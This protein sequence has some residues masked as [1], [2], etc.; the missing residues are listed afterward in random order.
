[1][2]PEPYDVIVVG[3]G[4]AGLA[5]GATAAAGGASTLVL[6]AQRP[7]GR[8]RTIVRDGF[9][10]NLGP[11][12][13]YLGGPGMRVLRSLAV[14]PEGGSPPLGRYRLLAGGRLHLLPTSPG[15]LVRTTALGTRS[16]ARFGRLMAG[17]ARM[18]ASR[19]AGVSASEWLAGFGLRPD[20]LSVAAAL[21]RLG[22]YC[23]DLGHLSADAALRQLQLG[24][25]SGVLYLDG[26]WQTLVDALA[27]RVEVRSH[28]RVTSVEAAGKLTEV[29]VTASAGEPFRLR[30]G[31]VVVAVGA[32]RAAGLLLGDAAA[33]GWGDL[34]TAVEAA[35]L[36]VAAR[37]VPAPGWILGADDPVYGTTQ[38]PPAR[39]AP[40]GQAVV[41]LIRYAPRTAAEDR[42][43]LQA[44]RRELG[45]A[46]EDVIFERFLARM[47]V[48][49]A[50]PRAETGGLP[51]R[52]AVDATG[53]PSVYLAGDWVGPD[54]LL[55]DAALAS[56]QQAG[57]R[58]LRALGRS[59]SAAGTR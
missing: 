59:P 55:A 10:C 19:L 24:A 21:I 54:G 3:A 34:G 26:G 52:P 37:R 9:R 20:A 25:D 50:M 40:D 53:L 27:A 33:Q 13:L 2:R 29:E 39:L 23:A 17:F 30:A 11:H 47:T 57:R 56:G 44:L 46:D 7:G 58:A 43:A 8:A 14:R 4:L 35:C 41:S 36:D 15:S 6:A 18:D 42:L 51:G 48:A 31:A 49:G 1:M 38:G 32:P 12:A 28:Q 22:T 5:A 45:V 16:K